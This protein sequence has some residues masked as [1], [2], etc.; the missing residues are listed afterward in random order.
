MQ[1]KFMVIIFNWSCDSYSGTG[2]FDSRDMGY[3]SVCIDGIWH[4]DIDKIEIQ[5]YK[6]DIIIQQVEI[7]ML[8]SKIDFYLKLNSIN[9]MQV[10]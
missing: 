9:W 2:A 8:I 7:D 4:Q 1:L 10:C 3:D 5:K 6:Y